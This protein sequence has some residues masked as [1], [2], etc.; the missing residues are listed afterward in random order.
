M[1]VGYGWTF[2]P[3]AG[4]P[5]GIG[6]FIGGAGAAPEVRTFDQP[7]R[8]RIGFFVQAQNLTNRAN[9]TGYSGTMTSPFFLQPTAVAGTR[10]VEA[11][12]NFGF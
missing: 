12:I 6:V 3:P 8:Y 7:A 10:R 5:P 11:G 1:N 4:G 2:G 9:Y